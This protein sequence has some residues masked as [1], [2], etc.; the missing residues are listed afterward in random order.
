[1][2]SLLIGGGGI[3]DVFWDASVRMYCGSMAGWTA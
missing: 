1:M 2:M 3:K